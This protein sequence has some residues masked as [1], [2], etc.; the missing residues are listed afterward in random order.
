MY[1]ADKANRKTIRNEN[2]RRAKIIS[3]INKEI[4][5][6]VK[7]GYSAVEHTFFEGDKKY[8]KEISDL[9]ITK[10]YKVEQISSII[11]LMNYTDLI[12]S[13]KDE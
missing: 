1:N 5:N 9:L 2:R 8:I 12:I 7:K 13:W 6:A 3:M 11:S 10:G 4:K